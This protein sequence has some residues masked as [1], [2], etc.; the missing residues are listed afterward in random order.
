MRKPTPA[1]RPSS[2]KQG[3]MTQQQQL[4]A[5]LEAI[6][7]LKA[8]VEGLRRDLGELKQEAE[9]SEGRSRDS[10]ARLYERV[11]ELALTTARVEG[12]ATGHRDFGAGARRRRAL[13]QQG[14]GTQPQARCPHQGSDADRSEGEAS[15]VAGDPVPDRAHRRGRPSLVPGH[16]ERRRDLEGAAGSAATRVAFLPHRLCP[17]LCPKSCPNLSATGA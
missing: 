13:G 16:P 6:G 10:R 1:S 5:I 4:G 11:E 3:T 9:A 15:G 14:R 8:H 2:G 7:G 17:N 12:E